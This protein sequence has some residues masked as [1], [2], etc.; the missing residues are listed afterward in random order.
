MKRTRKNAGFTLIE[1]LVTMVVIVI[2][3]AGVTVSMDAGSK[4]YRQGIFESDSSLLAETLNYNL[5]DALR[6]ATRI[7]V[8]NSREPFVDSASNILY[9]EQVPCVF[10]N[11]SY[12]AQEAYLTVSTSG[13][14]VI[15]LK[16]L[17]NMDQC[18]LVNMGAYP[19][20]AIK[21]LSV[22]YYEENTSAT[23]TVQYGSY[24]DISYTIQSVDFPDYT[25]DVQ[26]VVR[27][28]NNP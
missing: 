23:G 15:V 5:G 19:D 25:K 17:K 6:N 9:P 8:N 10:T 18:E 11:S 4:V 24:F 14:Q 1:V 12:G 26:L 16:N 21:N 27:V 13:N 3:F 20:L 22:K 28:L 7:R 2:L